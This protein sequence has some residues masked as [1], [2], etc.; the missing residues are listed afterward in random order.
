MTATHLPP[1]GVRC[2][3]QGGS[4]VPSTGGTR[5]SLPVWR[6][7]CWPWSQP[8]RRPPC[9]Q[10]QDPPRPTVCKSLLCK[11]T[12]CRVQLRFEFLLS[13]WLASGP[14][15]TNTSISWW[16]QWCYLPYRIMVRSK[17]AN[18]DTELDKHY[19]WYRWW[20]LL[21]LQIHI[22]CKISKIHTGDRRKGKHSATTFF[23]PGIPICPSLP[24]YCFPLSTILP[25]LKPMSSPSLH[26]KQVTEAKVSVCLMND[27]SLPLPGLPSTAVHLLKR[28]V[29]KREKEQNSWKSPVQIW[30]CLSEIKSLRI[31]LLPIGCPINMS[32]TGKT[33][34]TAERM[35]QPLI[36]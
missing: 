29:R 10:F 16:G 36:S 2:G 24:L 32:P 26:P 25:F 33:R 5:Q 9:M 3:A 17:E 14:K 8:P 20:A 13:S 4:Q 1:G 27:F 35:T 34:R 22:P 12:D 6:H 23:L 28:S 21:L 31:T 18:A 19:K 30:L 15:L 11:N 7:L